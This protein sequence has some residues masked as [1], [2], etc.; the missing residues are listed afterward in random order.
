[1][2]HLIPSIRPNPKGLE[3]ALSGKAAGVTTSSQSASNRK[4]DAVNYFR[5]QIITSDD[6]PLSNAVLKLSDKNQA[7]TTDNNGNFMI[8]PL[9]PLSKSM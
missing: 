9:I 4:K 3:R 2:L 1:M 8:P 7:Y 6:K 5:G